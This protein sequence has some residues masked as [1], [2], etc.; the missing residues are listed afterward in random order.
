MAWPV[1]LLLYA[2]LLSA[3][4]QVRDENGLTG[5]WSGTYVCAQGLMALD[6][7]MEEADGGRT[8]ALFHFSPDP[9][10]PHVPEGCFTMAGHFYAAGRWLILQ[11]GEWL[12]RPPR[13]V[14]V[15]LDGLLDPLTGVISGRVTG[16]PGC[17][18]FT[19][20]RVSAPTAPVTTCHLGRPGIGA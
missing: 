3:V 2:G 12:I 7:S 15:G 20:R 1:T 4:I 6:L 14:T 16:A 8:T 19:L 11:P 9:I 10:N 17:T 5:Q 13:Y 18:R